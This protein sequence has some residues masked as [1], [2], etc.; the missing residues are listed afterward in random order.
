MDDDPIY[1]NKW[2]YYPWLKNS[3]LDFL[4]NKDDLDRINGLGLVLC[5]AEEEDYITVKNS[6]NVIRVKREGIQK[7]LPSPKFIWKEIV[8]DRDDFKAKIEDLFWHH[9][10]NQ[11]LYYITINGKSKSK[12]FS[13]GEILSL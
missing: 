9:N 3:D 4:I 6:Q 8:Y 13:D 1:L 11:Y 10:K 2:L 12:R 5:I 7:I